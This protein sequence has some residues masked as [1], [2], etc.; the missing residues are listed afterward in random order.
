MLINNVDSA[1][2]LIKKMTNN[3]TYICM[4]ADTRVGWGISCTISEFGIK[5][6]DI[7][8][9]DRPMIQ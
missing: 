2:E 5:L 6:C 7:Y 8:L 4:Y 3:C 1:V 9:K